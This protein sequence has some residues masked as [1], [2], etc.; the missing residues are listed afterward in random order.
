M[1]IRKFPVTGVTLQELGARRLRWA[2]AFLACVLVVGVGSVFWSGPDGSPQAVM[3]TLQ[4]SLAIAFLDSALIMTVG[5]VAAGLKASHPWSV[6]GQT[7]GGVVALAIAGFAGVP[8]QVL[9]GG[10]AGV[11]L[12]QILVA[13]DMTDINSFG[14]GARSVG[15]LAVAVLAVVALGC[16]HILVWNPQT[17]VP[18]KPLPQI[19]AALQDSGQGTGIIAVAV[20]A[21]FWLAATIAF[22][23]A[24]VRAQAC[25]WATL[26]G[27]G[28]I[29][30]ACAT[31]WVAGFSTAM[32]LADTFAISGADAASTGLLLNLVGQITLVVALIWGISPQPV[33]QRAARRTQHA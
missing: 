13:L 26:V 20:W 9:L 24:G 17:A 18:G 30:G 33:H 27:L 4:Q 23:V 11:I 31:A 32:S 16:L 21:A 3:G 6:L 25:G 1:S 22:V 2:G 10:V 14:S 15:G 29:G 7:A 19:Y 12:L 5:A 8:L 28:M